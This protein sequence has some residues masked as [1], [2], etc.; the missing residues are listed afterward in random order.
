MT[1]CRNSQNYSEMLLQIEIAKE[2]WKKGRFSCRIAPKF[3]LFDPTLVVSDVLNGHICL[4]LQT[5]PL[6]C[7]PCP[8][9]EIIQSGITK[10]ISWDEIQDEI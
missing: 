1:G 4:F 7:I 5:E 9:G 6:F 3:V 2:F 10:L 8:S